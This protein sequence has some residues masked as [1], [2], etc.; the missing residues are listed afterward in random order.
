M[1]TVIF[2]VL[3]SWICSFAPAQE[4]EFTGIHKVGVTPVKN[5]GKTGTC[6]SFST[7]SFIESELLRMGKGEFDLSEMF[8]IRHSYVAK[9]ENYMRYHGVAN[10]GPEGQAHNALDVV[11][12]FGFVP[13]CAYRGLEYG[14]GMH[15]HAELDGVTSS[16]LK[17][18]LEKKILTTGWK[19]GF[20]GILDGYLGEVPKKITVEEETMTPV[21]FAGM[22]SF[23][24]DNYVEITSFSHHPYYEK[25][26]LELPYNWSNGQYYNLP[27]G[28]FMEVM[29]NALKKG[30]SFC[31]DGDLEK[32]QF[33]F[34]EGIA[35]IEE[36]PEEIDIQQK[37]QQDFDNWDT[38]D[39]HL[40]HVVGVAED[41]KGEKFFITKNSWGETNDLGG[42]VN[43][44]F[45]Y[46]SLKTI[47]IMVHKDAIPKKIAAKI[48]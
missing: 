2:I 6:W 34:S 7:T 4:R 43:M 48:F 46:V 44:S 8:F 12:K 39:E 9:A 40:M 5:Q 35:N 31:W 10:F 15:N 42:Y 25:F 28:E 1:R 23:N 14:I 29:E 19:K 37:R 16:Y 30:Y 38:T 24:P 26:V 41:E 20:I 27:I 17:A 3:L 47:A 32:D 21:Q 18:L 45:D 13:E 33:S 36:F 11:R 22:L